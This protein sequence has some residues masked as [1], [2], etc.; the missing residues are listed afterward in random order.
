MGNRAVITIAPY[1]DDD[2]GIYL[3][4]NG[5]SDSVEAFLKAAKEMGFRSP[6]TDPAYCMARLTQTIANYFGITDTSIG[7]GV[8][9]S[10]DCDNGDNGVFLIGGD[11]EIV[12]RMHS[13]REQMEYDVGK[14]AAAVVAKNR[15][16]EQELAN[17]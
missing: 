16:I 7:I 5:G 15:L 1:S 2:V 3:H 12:G 9:K 17:G 10:L 14:L 6:G 8:C 11:W 4:W 13:G